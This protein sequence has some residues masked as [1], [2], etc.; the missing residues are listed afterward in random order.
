VATSTPSRNSSPRSSSQSLYAFPDRPGTRSSSRA[1]GVPSSPGVR[2]TMPVNCFGPRPPSAIGN[3]LTWC[4]TC[5]STPSSSTPRRLTPVNRDS[6]SAMTCSNGSM[7]AHT[8][9]QVVPSCR[10][11]PRME[12]C[13]RRIW[14]IAHQHALLVSNARGGATSGSCSV[15]AFVGHDGSSHRQIRLRHTSFTGRSRHGAS[16]STTSR[17]PWLPAITPQEVQPIGAGDDSTPTLSRPTPWSNSTAVTCR[18]P[19]PTSRS[20]REQYEVS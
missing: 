4:H 19:S 15:N 13:S 18:P 12:A 2:S 17:R 6:S 16:A 3:S 11:I 9:F 5:S 20:Q 8:V 7:Q 1:L 10:A 14:L